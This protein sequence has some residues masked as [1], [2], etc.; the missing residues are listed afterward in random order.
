MMMV[1]AGDSG[2]GVGK[3][4]LGSRISCLFTGDKQMTLNMDIVRLITDALKL[5]QPKTKSELLKWA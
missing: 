1:L 3:T 4:D 2:K 5:T